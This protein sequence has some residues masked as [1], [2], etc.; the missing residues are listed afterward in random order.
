MA[1]A[2]TPLKPEADHAVA[3]AAAD[4]GAAAA[5]AAAAS[6]VGDPSAAAAGASEA[7]LSAAREAQAAVLC[8]IAKALTRQGA[9]HSAGAR[10]ACANLRLQLV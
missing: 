10:L 5:A 6:G 1:E 4:A 3:A 9:F 2:M 8:T 7:T